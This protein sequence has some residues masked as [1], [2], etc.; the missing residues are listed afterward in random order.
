MREY[1]AALEDILQNG[2]YRNNRTGTDTLSKFGLN[3]KIDL[4]KGFPL[5]TTKKVFDKGIFGELVWM[6]N[7][8]TNVRFLQEQGIHIWD[9]WADADGNLGP[10]YGKQWRDWSGIDQIK[11]IIDQLTHDP[12]SRRIILTN[13]NVAELSQMALPPCHILAQFNVRGKFL[14]CAVY[15]RSGDMFLGVPFDIAEYAALVHLLCYWCHYLP[16][17]LFFNFGD[18]HIYVNHMAQ[19][20]EQ[21]KREPGQLPTLEI[22]KGTTLDNL[23]IESFILHGYNP[24]PAIRGAVAI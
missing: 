18:A 8:E 6:L 1:L 19:V 16:G 9:A 17:N 4:Q 3:I 13:W 20:H 10:V 5:L 15:Q 23:A 21:L 7:G 11:T 2:E 22:A 14:D 12:N 24:M